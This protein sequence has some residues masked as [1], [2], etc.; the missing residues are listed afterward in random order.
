MEPPNGSKH[1]PLENKVEKWGNEME[2]EVQN[3]VV[4]WNGKFLEYS[5]DEEDNDYDSPSPSSDLDNSSNFFSGSGRDEKLNFIESDESGAE[6]KSDEAEIRNLNVKFE[7]KITWRTWCSRNFCVRII[8][9][10]WH[11]QGQILI[12]LA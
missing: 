2:N 4:N 1:R 3:L 8:C 10:S 5:S 9:E 12:L 6:L 7:Q 11:Y